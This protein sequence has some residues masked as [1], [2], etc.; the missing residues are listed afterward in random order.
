MITI[1]IITICII[2]KCNFHHFHYQHLYHHHNIHEFNNFYRMRSPQG[3]PG[4]SGVLNTGM[5][6][7]LIINNVDDF[8]DLI[9]I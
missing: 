2:A 1:F 8:D 5:V 6:R 4:F 7:V 3:L 9:I